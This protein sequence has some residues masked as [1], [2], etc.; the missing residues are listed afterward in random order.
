VHGRKMSSETRS[1]TAHAGAIYV[2]PQLC[3]AQSPELAPR[4]G[5]VTVVTLSVSL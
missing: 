1:A 3:R 5:L 4:P 2:C